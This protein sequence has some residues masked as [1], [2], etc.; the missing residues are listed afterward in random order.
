[1]NRL[2]L[3]HYARLIKRQ[4][5]SGRKFNKN[6]FVKYKNYLKY[7]L[8][9]KNEIIDWN[10]VA[11][12]YTSLIITKRCN[13]NC[14]FCIVKDMIKEK[15][16]DYDLST[17]QAEKIFQ[18]TMINK[19]LMMMLTG[20]EPLLNS[21]IL[22]I[23]KVAKSFGHLVGITTN[24]TLLPKYI[25]GLIDAG[26]DSIS[27]SLYDS[28]MMVLQDNLKKVAAK[29]P[30]RIN[31]MIRKKDIADFTSVENICSL[32]RD[33]G[34]YGVL[35]QNMIP[36][37]INEIN[38]VIFEDNQ[39]YFKVQRLINRKYGNQLLISWPGVVA[40]TIRGSRDK[41]CRMPWWLTVVDAQGNLGLCCRYQEG[42]YGNIFYDDA[43]TIKNDLIWRKV[44][45][46]LLSNSPDIPAECENCYLLN[47][48]YA[49][50]I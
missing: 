31:K 39:Q 5:L 49:S 42:Q 6:G 46:S 40:K 11:P 43:E 29:F 4:V 3:K 15:T 33:T 22:E 7:R 27:V 30:I 37:D 12:V 2:K 10:N 9:K 1:M 19:S 13:L 50:N 28:T 48:P 47:D 21:N 32:A 25:D 17:A 23:V 41:K 14:S 36:S 34:C 26:I 8:C 24:A 16:R 18:H 44:R 38:D 45:G 35:F 20:G